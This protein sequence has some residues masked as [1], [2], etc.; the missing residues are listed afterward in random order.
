MNTENNYVTWAVGLVVIALIIGSGI[1][2]SVSKVEVPA[3]SDLVIDVSTSTPAT[4]TPSAGTTPDTSAPTETPA[5]S[6]AQAAAAKKAQFDAEM[7]KGDDAYKAGNYQQART[8][9]EAAAKIDPSGYNVF[10]SLGQLYAVNLKDNAK[11]ELN[12]LMAIKNT[13]APYS[14]PLYRNL[15]DFYKN[16]NRDFSAI[17]RILKDAIARTPAATEFYV[18]L[19]REYK[20]QG[21]LPEARLQYDAA[22]KSAGTNATLVAQLQAEK[23]SF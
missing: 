21:L 13:P 20:A 9:W 16:T 15:Y 19:A 10:A 11:A 1:W 23:A 2:Y 17:E 22:I 14:A 6:E 3:E 12:Y 18:L 5:P 4:T 7:K 8:A